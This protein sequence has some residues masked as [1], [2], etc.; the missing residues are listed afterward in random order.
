[1]TK[2]IVCFDSGEI[3]INTFGTDW[4]DCAC[5]NTR[6]KWIDPYAGT[7]VVAARDKSHVRLLGLNNQYLLPA[8]KGTLLG[9]D[10][11]WPDYRTLHDQATTVP[12][13][14]F[15]KSKAGCWAVVVSIGLTSDVRW[16]T[17]EEWPEA[18]AYKEEEGLTP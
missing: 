11:L 16:A 7:V 15:D 5:G 10:L 13:H 6:A 4:T 14:V 17:D 9:K 18:F 3:H 1:M 2:A 12:T 8:I